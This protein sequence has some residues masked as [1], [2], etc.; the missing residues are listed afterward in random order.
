MQLINTKYRDLIHKLTRYQFSIAFFAFFLI[1]YQPLFAF[2]AYSNSE[3]EE[4][5]KEFIQQINQSSNVER[6][7][8]AN[9]YLRHIAR[10]LTKPSGIKTP[11][12]FI[13]KSPEIN[14]F[15]GP[16][17]Y[18]GVNTQLI[19]ATETEH[20]L[21]AV[22][23]HETAHVELHHLYHMLEHQKQMRIPMLASLLASFAL[24]IINPTL[25]GGALMAS[26]TGYAQENINY[27]RS[28]EKEA[29]RVGINMMMK[30]NFD[31]KGMAGF[32]KKMQTHSRYYYTD[33]IPA[34]L[35]THPLDED[36]IA[37]AENRSKKSKR[38]FF[39]QSEE[40]PLFKE[41]IRNRVTGNKKRLIDFYT[42][43]CK[44]NYPYYACDY[45][46][47]L[48]LISNHQYS[49]AKQVLSSLI[50][51]HGEQLYYQIALA[52]SET[53]LKEYNLAIKRLEELFQ[54]YP[55]NYAV[56]SFYSDGLIAAGK[57]EKAVSLL[58]KGNRVFKKDLQL[59]Y[60]LALAQ[61][62]AKKNG[63]A[64]FTRS[65]CLILEG[66]HRAAIQQLKVAQKIS[67]KDE[68]LQARISALIDEIKYQLKK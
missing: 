38:V 4:L 66:R 14:A 50:K 22:M 47:S 31:P 23:A 26:M 56:L 15:A 32:F 9:Q 46:Y 2:S 53:E 18:I 25:G 68:Y 37:E 13:V 20:E 3:L 62:K 67:K 30:A 54:N 34:I 55:D 10:K 60:R 21:A 19:L 59:C 36:R 43:Q 8:L 58:L 28:N 61:S 17:G 1:T 52:Q 27:V 35:R 40:Y 39:P 65:E 11:Y 6:N 5:E 45:G 64:Y 48:T 7:P 42:K 57:A 16:G 41:L 33:N 29:D 51:N 49:K 44:K 12:F 63:Y 24:G